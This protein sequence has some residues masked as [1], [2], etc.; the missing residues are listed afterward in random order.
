VLSSTSPQ[1]ASMPALRSSDTDTLPEK[2]CHAL[3]ARFSD[4]TGAAEVLTSVLS[5]DCTWETP[6]FVAKGSGD[7]LKYLD[8]FLEFFIDPTILFT[9]L[10]ADGTG[11]RNNELTWLVSFTYPLPWR[12]RVTLSGSTTLELSSTTPAPAS[13]EIVQILDT[14]DVPAWNIGYQILPRLSDVLWVYPSPHA[15]TDSGTRRKISE[16]KGYSVILAA[17]RPVLLVQAE[18]PKED[19]LYVFAVPALPSDAFVGGLRRQEEYATISPISVRRVAGD[20]FEWEV[21]V[22]GNMFGNSTIQPPP[23]SSPNARFHVTSPRRFAVVRYSGYA[24][25]EIFDEKLETLVTSL[26]MDGVLPGGGPVDRSK[27]W[28]RSYDSKVGFNAKGLLA[29]ATYGTTR[30]IPPRVN[31][32]AIEIPDDSPVA[33]N[34]ST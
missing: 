5:T 10:R 30:G 20:L 7:V 33:L 12:P 17:A 11:D 16:H 29:I 9:R 25:T 2:L 4:S 3:A 31:E 32:I 34:Y 13:R 1:P 8:S 21:P 14:W 23:H 24:L 15:E 19:Q 22:P 26:Q 28:A 6:L 18:L 27:V